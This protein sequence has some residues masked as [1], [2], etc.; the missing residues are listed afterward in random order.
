MIDLSNDMTLEIVAAREGITVIGWCSDDEGLKVSVVCPLG[1]VCDKP[2]A[3]VYIVE[4]KKVPV[5]FVEFSNEGGRLIRGDAKEVK[6][7]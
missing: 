3:L 6:N 5:R 7:A 1:I 4:R 2:F